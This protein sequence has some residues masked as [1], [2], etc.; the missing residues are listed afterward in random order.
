M[1]EITELDRAEAKLRNWRS[2]P[3][4]MFQEL[5]AAIDVILASLD[6]ARRWR[7]LMDT[8]RFRVQ[9]SAGLD[10]EGNRN[11]GE[12][13][14]HFGMEFWSAYRADG[15]DAD[16][17]RARNMLT[18][19]AE[20]TML[21]PDAEAAIQAEKEDKAQRLDDFCLILAKDIRAVVR[22]LPQVGLHEAIA[23]SGRP[24]LD[25]ERTVIYL[26]SKGLVPKDAEVTDKI[27]LTERGT[28]V[29]KYLLDVFDEAKAD[30]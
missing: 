3:A 22:L 7:A 26:K 19:L 24:E 1:T 25:P 13:Y 14:I 5:D 30:M 8:A 10:R 4:H 11:P 29:R 18:A 17:E 28:E 9:G 2:K 21:G 16:N 27:A 12:P 15:A 20:L 23:L 6:D